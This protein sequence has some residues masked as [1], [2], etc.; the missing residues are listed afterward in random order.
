MTDHTYGFFIADVKGHGASAAIIVAILKEKL[1]E[2]KPYW[3]DPVRLFE[4]INRNLWQ[5]F[6]YPQ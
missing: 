6:E 1:Y 3:M 4:E 5:F 2:L